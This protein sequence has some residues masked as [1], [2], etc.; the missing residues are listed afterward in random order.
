MDLVCEL[1]KVHF[2]KFLILQ[3]THQRLRVLFVHELLQPLDMQLVILHTLAHRCNIVRE[4]RRFSS[5]L[6]LNLLSTLCVLF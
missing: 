4:G 6:C 5:A 1:A 2:G 3:L